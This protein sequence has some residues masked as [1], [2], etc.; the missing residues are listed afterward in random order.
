MASGVV[1][2]N[3][4]EILRE[5]ENLSEAEKSKLF[6]FLFQKLNFLSPSFDFWDNEEDAV[7]DD[8]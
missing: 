8:L 5:I 2:V 4:D 6:S 3:A 7:Y 1:S